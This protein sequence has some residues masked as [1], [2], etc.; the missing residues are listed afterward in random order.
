[1]KRAPFVKIRLIPHECITAL[2]ACQEGFILDILAEACHNR[3]INIKY[4]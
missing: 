2:G 1:M 3:I 4:G